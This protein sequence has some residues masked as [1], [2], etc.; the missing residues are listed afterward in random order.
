MSG[1][2]ESSI[3][4]AVNGYAKVSGIIVRKLNNA[5]DD[6]WPDRLYV[7][8]FGHHFYIEYKRPGEPPRKLQIYR[9]WTLCM[10]NCDVYVIDS[11]EEGKNVIDYYKRG[12]LD[13]A[14]VSRARH[15]DYD[16]T[17][18]CRAAPRSRPRK[19]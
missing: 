13:A 3:E 14:P 17:V 7:S 1:R 15:Q 11:V 9:V 19:D 8:K 4:D 10:W 6:G 2:L 12:K 16:P 5:A 18:R